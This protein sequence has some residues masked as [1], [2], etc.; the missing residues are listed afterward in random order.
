MGNVEDVH[1][2]NNRTDDK[3]DQRQ[4]AN[5]RVPSALHLE[6]D[7]VYRK[8]HVDQ[9]VDDGHVYSR[10]ERDRVEEDYPW[11]CERD[12]VETNE[13][14]VLDGYRRLDF[15]LPRDVFTE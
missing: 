8:E 13:C 9:A 14:S 7:W 4:F 1:A 6:D 10:Q 2:A 12:L 11:A 5:S 3:A 15:F